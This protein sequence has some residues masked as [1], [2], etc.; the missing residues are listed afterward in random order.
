MKHIIKGL[1][2]TLMSTAQR[3]NLNNVTLNEFRGS[4]MKTFC[5]ALLA[6]VSTLPG[7][8][9]AVMSDADVSE[10]LDLVVQGVSRSL[11]ARL[12]S[13]TTL[14]A[15]ENIGARTLRY[16]YTLETSSDSELVMRMT[17]DTMDVTLSKTYCE[18]ADLSWYRENNVGIAWA[19][20]N[21]SDTTVFTIYKD[22]RLCE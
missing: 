9:M 4:S 2:L 13:A 18:D 20:R 10:Q 6:L 14:V 19:Y 21:E 17:A 3:V 22:N 5:L 8:T 1:L 11:P 15:V 7:H 12:D 16:L